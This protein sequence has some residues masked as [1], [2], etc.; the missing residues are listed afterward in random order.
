MLLTAARLLLS[1]KRYHMKDSSS[2]VLFG[3]LAG[4]ATGAVLALL[5]SPDNGK[6]IRKTLLS[7]LEDWGD[8]VKDKS[9][10]LLADLKSSSSDLYEDVEDYKDKAV[11]E[12][13]SKY[14]EVK[15][16]L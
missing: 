6:N 3:I 1:T 14:K 11:K 8:I 15:N 2:K 16:N 4:A 9:E 13:K 12:T 7:T 5:F 10:S